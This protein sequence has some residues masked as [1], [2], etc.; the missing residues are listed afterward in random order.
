LV[1]WIHLYKGGLTHWTFKHFCAFWRQAIEDTVTYAICLGEAFRDFYC[2]SVAAER[3]AELDTDGSGSLEGEERTAMIGWILS[4]IYGA[5]P[6]ANVQREMEVEVRHFQMRLD[7]DGDS[8]ITFGELHQ[9]IFDHIKW[10]ESLRERQ[11]LAQE[12]AKDRAIAVLQSAARG[13]L[14]RRA[15]RDLLMRSIPQDCQDSMLFIDH[16]PLAD[17]QPYKIRSFALKYWGATRAVAVRSKANSELVK[18][19]TEDAGRCWAILW[20][21]SKDRV[22]LA[23][24]GQEEAMAANQQHLEATNHGPVSFSA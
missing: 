8:K 14:Q 20:L 11:G 21:E 5:N 18:S 22:A 13:W 16:I 10:M 19:K 9:Y 1:E 3:F 2:R 24:E 6:T 12:A 4:F 7:L 15:L 23:L 17:A